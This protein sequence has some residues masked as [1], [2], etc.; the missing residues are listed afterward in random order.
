MQPATQNKTGCVPCLDK[1][2][3]RPV[4]RKLKKKNIKT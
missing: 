3:V 2:I 1:C 4:Y